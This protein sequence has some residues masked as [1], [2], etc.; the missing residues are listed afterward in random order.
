MP[1]GLCAD[2]AQ[3]VAAQNAFVRIRTQ[4][5]LHQH[6]EAGLL[7][8]F[9]LFYLQG[10][11]HLRQQFAP[12]PVGQKAVVAHHFKV[13]RRDMTDISPDHIFLRQRLLPVLLRTVVIIVVHHRAAAVVPELCR[14]HRRPFQVPAQVFDATPRA[15]GLFGEVDLPAASVLGLKVTLPL[16]FIT[17]MP[18]PR[19]AAGVNQVITV[20]QQADDGS[21]PDF[22][23]I[24]FFKEE[25]APDTMLNIESATGDGEVNV[26][27]LVKLSAVGVQGAEDTDLHGLF[28]G[29][30]EHGAG[31]GTEQ[32]IEQRPVVVEKGP[33]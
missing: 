29:L 10:F 6:G 8:F 1:A 2:K 31:G 32:G 27:M 20:A 23:Y 13:L 25:V 18:Q 5:F 4:K 30:P 15:S 12:F 3:T 24:V 17:D 7:R 9:P 16:F 11:I 19:Q 28:S 21:A 14:R 22:F 26:R 33:Q